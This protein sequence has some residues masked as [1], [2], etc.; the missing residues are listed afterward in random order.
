MFCWSENLP[1]VWASLY[2]YNEYLLDFLMGIILSDEKESPCFF[3]SLAWNPLISAVV[4]PAWPQW[5]TGTCESNSLI[6][7]PLKTRTQLSF[8]SIF[9]TGCQS[10]Y[11]DPVAAG[12]LPLTFARHCMNVTV[13]CR[14]SR[15]LDSL[16]FRVVSSCPVACKAVELRG[17]DA[18]AH[19]QIRG[20]PNNQLE[21]KYL[22]CISV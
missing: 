11:R 3:F 4:F 19:I 7:R 14:S 13:V 2:L 10:S 15:L 16:T 21:Y 9:L 8:D 1:S 18:T 6:G 5:R 12:G 22:R 20:H 17:K